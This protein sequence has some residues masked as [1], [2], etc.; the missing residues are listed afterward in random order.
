[1][2]ILITKE[3]GVHFPTLRN[4]V[5]SVESNPDGFAMA[6]NYNGSIVTFKT[7]NAD[8]FIAEYKHVLRALNPRNTAMIIHARIATHGTVKESNCHCWTAKV[9]GSQMAFAHN[10]IL[11]LKPY[12]DMTDSETFLRKYIQPCKN[13]SQFLWTVERFIGASKFAFMDADGNILRFGPF[14]EERGV[15]Y[16][17]RSYMKYNARCADPRLWDSYAI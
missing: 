17:N 13:I 2:C 12:S 3:K 16:S 10:G 11:S 9:L 4:I 1:M 14:I 7:L 8:E 6:Y 5:N 15:Q